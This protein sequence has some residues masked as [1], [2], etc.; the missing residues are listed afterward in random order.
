MPAPSDRIPQRG[1]KVAP[2]APAPSRRSAPRKS[3]P[4]KPAPR[5]STRQPRAASWPWRT[6]LLRLVLALSAPSAL[7]VIYMDA[8]IQREFSGKKWSVP[9]MVYARPMELYAGAPVSMERVIEELDTLGYRAGSGAL[10]A[11][12]YVRGE[13][14]LRVATRSF[15]FWDGEEPARA[16]RLQF[17][18]GRVQSLQDGSGAELPIVRLEP[19]H[20]GGIYPAHNED[21]ILVRIADVP[22]LLV[23]ALMA[24]EDQNF[25]D[26]FGVSLRG[27]ARAFWVNVRSGALE[28]GGSTLTQQL[29]KNYFLTRE[30][31]FSRKLAELGMAVLLELHYSKDEIL[32][33]YLNE[34]YLGQDGHRAI[35]GF[36]LASHYYFNRPVAELDAQ[37]I[38]LLT[39]MVRGPS[40]Y[41]PWRNP[42]RALERRN[43]VLALM[44]QQGALDAQEAERLAALPLGMGNRE[45]AR[46]RYYPAYLD[47]VRRQLRQD[48]SDEHLGSEGLRVFTGLD[49]AVQRA[50]ERALQQTLERIE[51]DYAA[52]GKPQT[53]L[54]GA[55]IVTRV[56][57]GE[58]LAVVG[59]RQSRSAGFNRALDARRPVGSLMKPA[60]YLSAIADGRY[61]LLTPLDDS[62]VAYKGANGQIWRPRNYD[63]EDHGMVRLHRALAQSYNQSTARLGLEIGMQRV[64]DTIARLGIE[65]EVPPLPSVSLGAVSLTPIEVAGMYQT[66][67][68]GGFRSP[69][70][71]IRDVLD[72]SGTPLTRYPVAVEQTVS[73]AAVYVLE[74]ALREVMREGTARAAY[75][76]LPA[77]LTV[78]GKTG[79]TDDQRDSWFAGYAGDLLAVT[80]IGRDDNG[81]TPLTGASGALPVWVELMAGASR[82]PLRSRAPDG[83]VEAWVDP[84]SGGL[85]G[86]GCPGVLWMPFIAG[87]EPR[88][89]AACRGSRPLSPGDLAPAAPVPR[90]GDDPGPEQESWWRRWF[91]N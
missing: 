40:Y 76:T 43:T 71:A 6:A 3:D 17:A 1:V 2:A 12:V 63:R 15:R 81:V 82:E 14:Q 35:H 8:Y 52:R 91:G 67:A 86:E 77:S 66:M 64:V 53:G 72:Q 34:I 79:T 57:S 74:Y 30:R 84:V 25:R 60:V 19:V 37:Q 29:V 32:E 7:L 9:A 48:Y 33:A 85:S 61:N 23:D 80:W 26:H 24:V 65:R 42:E 62:P 31:T 70:R 16:L 54:E 58:V 20:I 13:S 59:G 51:R 27:I 10:R 69:L 87:T 18:G 68:S 38:A 83:V 75:R 36:G 90:A 89:E 28:Q 21:R 50:A 11:G 22:P 56:D 55:V 41:D 39:G 88:Y 4:R 47:L 49:P 46:S 78:A 44:R 45:Q 73:Q 5:K